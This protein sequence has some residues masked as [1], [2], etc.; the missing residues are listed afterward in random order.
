VKCVR[1]WVRCLVYNMSV[2]MNANVRLDETNELVRCE[3]WK[4]EEKL[5]RI[6]L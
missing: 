4:Q 5:R 6:W 3:V 1:E 2:N